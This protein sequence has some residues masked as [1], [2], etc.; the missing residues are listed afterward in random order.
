[1]D[2]QLTLIILGSIAIVALLVH[3]LWVSRK[4]NTP[5]AHWS[6]DEIDYDAPNIGIDSED[7]EGLDDPLA[8]NIDLPDPFND[9]DQFDEYGVGKVSTI[10]SKKT[11]PV[12][13]V[14]GGLPVVNSSEPSA[15]SIS[16]LD[17]IPRFD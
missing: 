12:E 6:K 15:S 3:G 4:S 14:D 10:S 11:E 2:L 7:V 9:I 8:E 1:M 17:D 5:Q 13:A 16:D